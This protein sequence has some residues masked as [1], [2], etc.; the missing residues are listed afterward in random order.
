MRVWIDLTNSPH[1]LFFAPIVK[2]LRA[3]GDEVLI[4]ARRFAHTI[5]LATE[6]LGAE[7]FVEV[8]TGSVTSIAGKIGALG[9]RTRALVPIA[10]NFNPDVAVSHGSYDQVLA[11]HALGVPSMVMV[12][13]EYQPANHLSFRLASHLLLP[14]AFDEADVVANG[15]RGKTDRYRGLKEEV[16][17]V[18]F[19][20]T[21]EQRIDLGLSDHTG[22]VVT[23]RPPPEGALYHR[24]ENPLWTTLLTHL[25]SLPHTRTLL[26]PRHPKHAVELQ[27]QW[28]SDKIRV[29]DKTVDGPA[30]VWWSD[31]VISGGGTMNREA[32]ALGTPVWSL[33]SGTLGGVDR[34]LIAD[35]RMH[36]LLEVADV[37]A[38]RPDVRTRGDQPHLV[39]D[40]RGQ[41]IA[42]IDKTATLNK[43]V[44]GRIGTTVKAGVGLA[45]K[46]VEMG[47]SKARTTVAGK[48]AGPVTQRAAA[49]AAPTMHKVAD[50]AASTVQETVD[51]VGPKVTDA[52]KKAPGPVQKLADKAAPTVK[53]V[54]DRAAP[55][56]QRL[57]DRAADTTDRAAS[58]GAPRRSAEPNLD[59]KRDDAEQS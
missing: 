50:Q 52:L 36:R 28:G 22:P 19:R 4:T 17:L 21:H 26:L 3:R 7:G 38:L 41:V 31:A 25:E 29:L 9:G 24:G 42:G 51:K 57:A 20:P 48:K 2:D 53:K 39:N 55:T 58:T 10:K 43:G 46:A 18:D 14:E 37:D 49:K 34:R 44:A 23:L 13:Y 11:A 30:L 45:G 8:G 16:Y 5:E 59:Q 15:G 27:Q 12:D 33:F 6:H 32:V 40:V 35:G 1:V 54:A 47:V 56:V